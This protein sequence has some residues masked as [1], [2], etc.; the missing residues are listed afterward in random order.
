MLETLSQAEPDEGSDRLDVL[1]V[2]RLVPCEFGRTVGKEHRTE[3]FRNWPQI[4]KYR[5]RHRV[6]PYPSVP[7]VL[8]RYFITELAAPLEIGRDVSADFDELLESRVGVLLQ[9]Y[10][11][12]PRR[13]LGLEGVSRL[14]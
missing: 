9:A 6:V 1:R 10:F 3:Q 7:D 4:E 12:L 13:R 5:H 11:F 8:I 2:D 14:K